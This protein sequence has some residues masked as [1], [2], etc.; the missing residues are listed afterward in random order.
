MKQ[1]STLKLARWVEAEELPVGGVC[2]VEDRA[3]L[4]ESLAQL[5]VAMGAGGEARAVELLARGAERVLLGEL[6]L[7]DSAA[8]E[9][10]VAQY[11]GERVGVWVR[12]APTAVSWSLAAEA[13]NAGFKCMMPSTG[14]AGWDVLLNDGT[15]TE[16]DAEWW[17]ARMLERGV[18]LV[19]VS[20][21]LQDADMN[22]CATLVLNHGDK[23]W[24]SP[25][26]DPDADLEPWVRWGQ[27]RQLVLPTPNLRDEAEMVRIGAP[28]MVMVE[29][30]ADAVAVAEIDGAI[31]GADAHAGECLRAA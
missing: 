13:P 14:V 1:I 12:S 21:D 16:T 17:I 27:A 25:R 4:P 19:L 6:A 23:L 24:F 10:L 11:G 26:L 15:P 29:E 7:T 28:A 8:V 18:S 2:F 22:I 31:S 5:N 30:S 9:R 20:I 3:G